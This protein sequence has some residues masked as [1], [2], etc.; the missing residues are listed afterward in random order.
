[1]LAAAL[2]TQPRVLLLDE[3]AAGASASRP[4]Q[5]RRA[6]RRAARQRPRAP[7][8]RAQPQVRAAGRRRGDRARSREAD[9]VGH[10]RRGRGERGRAHGVPGAAEALVIRARP[11]SWSA[12]G[13]AR[14]PG[15][16][17]DGGGSDKEQTLDIAVNAPFSKTPY[18]GRDDRRRRRARCGGRVREDEGGQVQASRS[19]ATTPGCRRAPPSRTSDA[20]SRTARWRS[21]T[22][23][24]ASNASWRIAADAGRPIGDHV[25][26]GRAGSIDAVTRPNVFRIAPTDHGMAFRFAEYLIPKRLK[27]GA[28]HRRLVLRTGGREGA[29][30]GSRAGPGV[31]R[32]QAHGSRGRARSGA[33]RCCVRGVR[34]RRHCSSGR[35]RPR[36]RACSRPHA[37]PAGTSRS[38]RLRP[39]RTRS[40]ASSS[41]TIRTGSTG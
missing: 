18:V 23:A 36:S 30:Q 25:P 27:V 15:C 13:G 24:P 31:G 5:P 38:T 16:G 14:W 41:R 19:S 26:G 4:R 7:R 39:V 32:D 2:A 20:Q 28:R 37:S 21:S 17:G 33:A 29:R 35:S 40:S 11:V 10:A 12:L 9:L 3:P 6:P 8:H 34:A 1:M 22:R